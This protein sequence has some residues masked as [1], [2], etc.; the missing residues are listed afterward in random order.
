MRPASA[1]ESADVLVVTEVLSVQLKSDAQLALFATSEH[2]LEVPKRQVVMPASG[3]AL[4][5][6]NVVV[7]VATKLTGLISTLL[8]VAGIVKAP[9]FGR[10]AGFPD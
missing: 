5:V 4:V 6:P 9:R 10:D 7:P 3:V 1:E 2:E 8:A